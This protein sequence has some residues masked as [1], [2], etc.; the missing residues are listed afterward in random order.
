ML[1]KEHYFGWR[2]GRFVPSLIACCAAIAM[3]ACSTVKDAYLVDTLTKEKSDKK[4][5][6]D[7]VG[8]S[9]E[10]YVPVPFDVYAEPFPGDTA[11]VRSAYTFASSDLGTSTTNRD[12]VMNY[13]I[14]R[15][16]K[17]CHTHEAGI[18]TTGAASNFVFSEGASILGGLGALLK[19][20][21][22][23]AALSG[24][25]A[26]VNATRDNFDQTFFQNLLA[27]AVVKSIEGTRLQKKNS[28]IVHVGK[29]RE[30]YTTAQMIAD[31]DDYHSSCSF[32]AGIVALTDAAARIGTSGD[33]LRA[34]ITDLVARR[35]ASMKLTADLTAQVFTMA[36]AEASKARD[37]DVAARAQETTQ[38][39]ARIAQ[40][41]LQ[42]S[43]VPTAGGASP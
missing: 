3:T 36:Q 41:T 37:A 32:Y 25:A 23:A 38:L 5:A 9:G 12:S 42:L 39:N 24:S 34:R 16:D 40:L 43:L 11:A 29:D 28:L 20:A 2:W 1:R 6:S 33:E 7:L 26:L 30:T 21:S 19:P 10:Q 35:D 4:I 13:L 22:T 8:L 27:G 17:I 18:V 31:V 15:S 14:D